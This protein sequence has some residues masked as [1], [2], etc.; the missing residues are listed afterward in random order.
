MKNNINE[1]ISKL[2]KKFDEFREDVKRMIGVAVEG[3]EKRVAIIAEQYSTVIEKI[4]R[5][6]ERIEILEERMRAVEETLSEHSKILREYSRILS[7]HTK[8]LEEHSRILEEHSIIL[9]E[10]T[11]ILQE[12]RFELKTRVSYNEF[13]K[14]LNRVANLEKKVQ[15]LSKKK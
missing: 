13:V 3:F 7:H 9:Q 10:H 15:Q 5:L 11:K 6:E 12:I 2:E 8:I 4:E 1:R 14:L